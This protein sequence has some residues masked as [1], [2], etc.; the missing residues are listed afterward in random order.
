MKFLAV[1]G[2]QVSCNMIF[3]ICRGGGWGSKMSANVFKG[4]RLTAN[5][6]ITHI[7]CPFAYSFAGLLWH[8]KGATCAFK[9]S[10]AFMELPS[11]SEDLRESRHRGWLSHDLIQSFLVAMGR[12]FLID[13]DA[14]CFEFVSQLI[15]KVGPKG[16]H[17]TVRFVWL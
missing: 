12:Q 7:G 6:W 13:V 8:D 11:G 2:S 3:Q 4:E 9:Q 1:S 16:G 5:N 15:K 17:L 14:K 10:V